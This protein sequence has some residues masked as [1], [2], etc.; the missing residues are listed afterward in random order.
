MI[1]L[2]F[3][4]FSLPYFDLYLPENWQSEESFL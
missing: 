4:Y 1:I 3:I 2:S